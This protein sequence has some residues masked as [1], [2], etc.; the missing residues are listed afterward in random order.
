METHSWRAGAGLCVLSSDFWFLRSH[1]SILVFC[2]Y[3]FYPISL[4]KDSNIFLQF[5]K[6]HYIKYATVSGFN[7]LSMHAGAIKKG[8]VCQRDVVFEYYV[9]P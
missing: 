9:P 2:I 7:H 6:L 3:L 5:P 1:F 4:P 8:I